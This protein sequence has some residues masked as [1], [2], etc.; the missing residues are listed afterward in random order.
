M[1]NLSVKPSLPFHLEKVGKLTVP[2]ADAEKQTHNDGYDKVFVSA[3]EDN[4]VLYGKDADFKTARVGSTVNFVDEQ[5]QAHQG[6]IKSSQDVDNTF[7]QGFSR[8][9]HSGFAKAAMLAAPL[10]GGAIQVARMPGIKAAAA[11]AAERSITPGAV[12]SFFN[13]LFRVPTHYPSAAEVASA[14]AAA[15]AGVS[16]KTV[17]LTGVAVGGAIS[18]G[19]P[20]FS[21]ISASKN[22]PDD[23]ALRDVTG[24]TTLQEK[25]Q[26]AVNKG[27]DVAAVVK[28]NTKPGEQPPV[29]VIQQQ[30]TVVVKENHGPDRTL[31]HLETAGEVAKGVGKAGAFILKTLAHDN[32]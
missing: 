2:L 3:G 30:K 9:I 4:F 10:A 22:K 20:V 11:D 17:I 16:P 14:R 26:R 6:T 15:V 19:I 29:I 32:D 28:A 7:S 27:E 13:T 1:S 18:L 8:S 24:Q 12:S 31:E 25:I 5:G 23:T 21:G